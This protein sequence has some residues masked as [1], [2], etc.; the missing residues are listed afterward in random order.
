MNTANR[1]APRKIV[2]SAE[3]FVFQ[4]LEVQ[5][6]GFCRNFPGETSISRC[7]PFESFVRGQFNV[8]A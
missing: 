8:R 4:S 3:N 6:M 5:E 1:C 7:I 2:R